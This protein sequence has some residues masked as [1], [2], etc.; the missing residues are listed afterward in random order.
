[1]GLCLAALAFL[2][3]YF[4]KQHYAKAIYANL[5]VEE[6]SM[7]AVESDAVAHLDEE[8]EEFQLI[9]RLA[10]EGSPHHFAT[11]LPLLQQRSIEVKRAA[12]GALQKLATSAAGRYTPLLISELIA[13][14]DRPFRSLCLLT[15]RK[16]LRLEQMRSLILTAP[17]L[18]PSEQIRIEEILIGLNMQATPV[19]TKMT[20]DE[21]LNHCSRILAGGALEKIA[22]HTLRSHLHE[23]VTPEIERAYLYLYHAKTSPTLASH[24][25]VAY[26]AS[27]RLIVHLIGLASHIADGELLF[28][29]LQNGNQ[30]L[31]SH[32]VETLEKNCPPK[33]FNLL[34]PLLEKEHH[35]TALLNHLKQRGHPL[36]HE[37]LVAYFKTPS[38]CIE[39][40]VI[41]S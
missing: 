24:L 6:K 19:L 18:R 12:I 37:E 8:S 38:S 7:E 15:I 5:H 3:A 33:L 20:L 36:T 23:L 22:P 4:L 27:L 35:K 21:E 9:H 30:D 39:R 11:I 34:L 40:E 28:R 2:S 41:S 13:T 31:H 29:S 17:H 14:D 25:E 32:A 10:K 1:M 26:L 16:T